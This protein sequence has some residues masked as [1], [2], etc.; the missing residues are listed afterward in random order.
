MIT[1]IRMQAGRPWY[2]IYSANVTT[3]LDPEDVVT[4]PWTELNYP[5]STWAAQA[6]VLNAATTSWTVLVEG[7]LNGKKAAWSLTLNHNNLSVMGADLPA[8]FVRCRLTAVKN[9]TTPEIE[10]NVVGNL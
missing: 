3:P 7:S 4:S 2:L 6:E 10:V 1:N 5:V 9:A 8:R